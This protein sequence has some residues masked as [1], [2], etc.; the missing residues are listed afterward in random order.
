MSIGIVGEIA[1]LFVRREPWI[2][3]A[4]CR[5]VCPD[6]FFPNPGE[7][8]KT[9]AAKRVC[10]LCEVPQGVPG[11]RAGTWRARG[12]LGRFVCW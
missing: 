10:G 8:S 3:K 5:E 2:E 4:L 6:D 7:A 11:V 9:T 12:D 1:R